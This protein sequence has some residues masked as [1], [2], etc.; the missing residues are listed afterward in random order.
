ML[1]VG[2]QDHLGAPG[3]DARDLA[4]DAGAV[5]HRLIERDAVMRALVD[6]DALAQ[7]V[8]LDVMIS[9]S[10]QCLISGGSEARSPRSSAFSCS[11]ALLA[12]DLQLELAHLRAQPL[13]LGAQRVARLEARGEPAPGELG[14]LT[15]TCTG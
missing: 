5:D 3:T 6:D 13:V 7:R 4:E 8:G 1:R 10:C 9:A 15:A 12:H 14:E 11:S 2:D